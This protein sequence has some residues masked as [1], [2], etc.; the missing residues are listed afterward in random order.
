MFFDGDSELLKK[1]QLDIVSFA[2]KLQME[3][4]LSASDP[5][6]GLIKGTLLEPLNPAYTISNYYKMS[7]QAEKEMLAK[8]S[9]KKLYTKSQLNKIMRFFYKNKMS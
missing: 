3:K 5:K 2:R 7:A 1:A 6:M 4:D 9:Y 8:Y